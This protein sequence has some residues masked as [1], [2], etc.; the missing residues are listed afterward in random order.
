MPLFSHFKAIL[1]L[2]KAKECADTVSPSY[3]LKWQ[4]KRL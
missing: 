1:T 2:L 4:K 3:R